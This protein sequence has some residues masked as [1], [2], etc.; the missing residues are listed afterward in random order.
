MRKAFARVSGKG[1]GRIVY[2]WTVRIAER[3]STGRPLWGCN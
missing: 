3:V 2:L 1:R